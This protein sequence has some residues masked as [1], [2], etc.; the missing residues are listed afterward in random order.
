MISILASVRP[1][2]AA[3]QYRHQHFL[4]RLSVLLSVY[5]TSS[6]QLSEY[7]LGTWS[8]SGLVAGSFRILA[9]TLKQANVQSLWLTSHLYLKEL[10]LFDPEKLR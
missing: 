1:L 3:P 6:R 4:L 5:Q 2:S 7:K 9:A 10:T 8:G